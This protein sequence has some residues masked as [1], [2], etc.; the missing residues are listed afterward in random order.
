MNNDE[1]QWNRVDLPRFGLAN[2]TFNLIVIGA[3]YFFIIGPLWDNGYLSL[4]G[5]PDGP[6][7]P[8]PEHIEASPDYPPQSA[9]PGVLE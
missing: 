1:R 5:G 7:T 6:P 4:I 8:I 9:R 2:T 3:L